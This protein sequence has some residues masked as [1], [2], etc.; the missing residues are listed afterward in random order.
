MTHA[1]VDVLGRRL[2]KGGVV[3]VIGVPDL[4]RMS[5]AGRRECEPVF[6]HLVGTYKKID[7]FDHFGDGM[8]L[9]ML[10]PP[11]SIESEQS[12]HLCALISCG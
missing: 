11:P 9:E 10:M 12:L 2:T 5:R 6:A 8:T 7:A 4:S 3:R 1:K